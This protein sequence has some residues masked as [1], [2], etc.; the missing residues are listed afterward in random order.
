MARWNLALGIALGVA[1]GLR[2]YGMCQMCGADLT[3]QISPG[4]SAVG[5]CTNAYPSTDSFV[6]NLLYSF[7]S[8]VSKE[9]PL[10]PVEKLNR[11]ACQSLLFCRLGEFV[12]LHEGHW[13]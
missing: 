5:I 10:L 12:P 1:V 6:L 13:R 9:S 4:C 8:K 2:G 3:T 7:L 11:W